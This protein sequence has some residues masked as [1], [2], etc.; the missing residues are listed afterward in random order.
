MTKL[1]WKDSIYDKS[2]FMCG[3]LTWNLGH[4]M[5]VLTYLF[6]YF[7]NILKL[8]LLLIKTRNSLLVVL[9]FMI[10]PSS[11]I[12]VPPVHVNKSFRMSWF[13]LS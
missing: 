6:R 2:K 11:Y 10:K 12:E 1:W 5:D 13:D 7:W 9:L 8:S 4:N 3:N